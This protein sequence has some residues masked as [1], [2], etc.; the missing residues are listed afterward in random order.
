MRLAYSLFSCLLTRWTS[1]RVGLTPALAAVLAL[2]LPGAHAVA[3]TTAAMPAVASTAPLPSGHPMLGLWQSTVV[4]PAADASRDVNSQTTSRTCRE[5]LDYRAH[6]I[7]LGTSAQ[8][9]TRAAFT[10]SPGPS[11]AGFYR[12]SET[13]LASNGRTDCAG[14]LHA[15]SDDTAVY[16]VQFSP[17]HD[18]FVLCKSESLVSCFG[19]FRR[20]P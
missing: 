15:V 13:L 16:F 14:D 5:T 20:Q 1:A 19:P 7:R 11:Q 12:L 4:I 10:V 17:K 6:H 8:E 2:M 9:I 18:Q 3:Q